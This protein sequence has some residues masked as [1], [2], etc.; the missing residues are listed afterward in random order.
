[1]AGNNSGRETKRVQCSGRRNVL[2][3]AGIA[4]LTATGFAGSVAAGD[5]DTDDNTCFDCTGS[6][7]DSCDEVDCVT[8]SDLDNW[9]D[10]HGDT[11]RWRYYEGGTWSDADYR[12]YEEVNT[13]L[14][15]YGTFN[16]CSG[17]YLHQFRLVGH[18]RREFDDKNDTQFY[19]D[20]DIRY[21]KFRIWEDSDRS[22]LTHSI[23]TSSDGDQ[24]AGCPM[25]D[26][27]T[28]DTIQDLL[29][30]AY[31]GG[32]VAVSKANPTIGAVWTACNLGINL[33]GVLD[34]PEKS[35]GEVKK[36][37]DY[38][39]SNRPAEI[40]HFIDFYVETEEG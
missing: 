20:P 1:M 40:G 8:C 16:N 36:K 26:D 33:I 29:D 18:G 31:T 11:D 38:L 21:H 28:Q 5:V 14:I 13:G 4:G 3:S 17:Q 23:F 37:F 22:D 10:Y 6:S 2:K 25:P 15:Y 9:S 30:L 34:Q 7:R 39:L 24:V 19:D 27:E 35:S 32:S 12:I